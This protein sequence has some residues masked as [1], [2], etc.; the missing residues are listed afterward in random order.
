MNNNKTG[1]KVNINL[2]RLLVYFFIKSCELNN[3]HVRQR[4][5]RPRSDITVHA[6]R[7]ERGKR[8]SMEVM[9]Q[10]LTLY[11]LW[12][13]CIYITYCTMKK[14]QI[15]HIRWFNWLWCRLVRHGGQLR[16]VWADVFN[17]TQHVCLLLRCVFSCLL[18]IRAY[19]GFVLEHLSISGFNSV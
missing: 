13:N 5:H 17:V 2:L 11:A 4:L 8:C 7:A 16:A 14:C 19:Y 9:L 6:A 18:W 3:A 1:I 12:I 10:T 15:Y